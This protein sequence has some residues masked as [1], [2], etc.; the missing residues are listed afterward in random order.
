[1]TRFGAIMKRAVE[2]TPDAV[3]GF[4]PPSPGCSTVGLSG[5][6]VSDSLMR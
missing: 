5:S 4:G 6:G 1:M 2:S 3:R